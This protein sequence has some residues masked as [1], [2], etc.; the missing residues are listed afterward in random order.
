MEKS[1]WSGFICM[2]CEYKFKTVKA[3][4]KASFGPK[5]CPKCGG[6][7]IELGPRGFNP[8]PLKEA[9]SNL[10]QAAADAGALSDEQIA[11]VAANARTKTLNAMS[12]F[13]S[14]LRDAEQA[15]KKG[16]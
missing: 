2:E 9:V 16:S 13:S 6:A 12:N 15:A 4:E 7:D 8:P 1:A 14:Y 3:A 11:L 5:G 10:F